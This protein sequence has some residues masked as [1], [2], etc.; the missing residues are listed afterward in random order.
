MPNLRDDIDRAAQAHRQL[1]ARHSADLLAK[2]QQLNSIL[3]VMERVRAEIP[4]VAWHAVR[5]LVDAEFF[6][7]RSDAEG[8]RDE[9]ELWAAYEEVRNAVS[10]ELRTTP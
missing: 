1:R 5:I 6:A 2:A 9:Q 3:P 8:F 4:Q 10:S 7:G